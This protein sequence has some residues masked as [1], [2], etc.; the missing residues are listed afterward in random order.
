M[1]CWERNANVK[2]VDIGRSL[3]SAISLTGLKWK[4]KGNGE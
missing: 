1:L 3:S 2:L 4:R